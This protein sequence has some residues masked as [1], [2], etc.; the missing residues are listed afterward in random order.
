MTRMD[1]GGPHR[2]ISLKGRKCRVGDVNWRK[3]L[4]KDRC[5][6]D[7]FGEP[8]DKK[9]SDLFSNIPLNLVLTDR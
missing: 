8:P 2:I 7:F 1:V 9:G 3:K 5:L 6:A 4:L